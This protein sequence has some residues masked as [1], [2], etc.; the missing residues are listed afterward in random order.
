MRRMRPS[1]L[2]SL[3]RYTLWSLASLV[4]VL[5]AISVVTLLGAH[6]PGFLGIGLAVL[7][8]VVLAVSMLLFFR[9]VEGTPPP[10][11]E[12]VVVVGAGIALLVAVVLSAWIGGKTVWII[13]GLAAGVLIASAAVRAPEGRR[14]RSGAVGLVAAAVVVAATEGPLNG[15]TVGSL[16]GVGFAVVAS[17]GT[18]LQWWTYEVA[19][20]LEEARA[21]AGE[22]AVAQ[23]RLR[24]AAELHDIQGHH[25]Q[26]IALKSELAARLGEQRPQD[27]IGLMREVQELARVALTDTRAVAG[28]Y[29]QVSF[30]TE[31]SNAVKVL[32]AAGIRAEAD[33]Q[34]APEGAAGRLLGLVVREATTNILRHSQARTVR[35]E[36]AMEERL[37]RL[38]ISNDGV[39]EPTGGGSGLSTLAGRLAEAGGRLRWTAAG[40]EFTVTATLEAS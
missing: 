21:V 36:L 8:T 28:A 17:G 10:R 33:F 34:T 9:G 1:P 16:V 23:E 6:R 22:L 11:G 13:W 37:A 38:T 19:R 15:L 5:W 31:L 24:F 35:L 18:G 26:V 27:A 20:K 3:R 30:A 25:L 12:R 4:G 32:A 40:G 2:V 7:V 29:R 14:V 39:A